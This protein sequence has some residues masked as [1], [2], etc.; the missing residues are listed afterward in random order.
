MK[1]IFILITIL[2]TQL[3][4]INPCFAI[5]I[6]LQT[7]MD[8]TYIGASTQ[9]QI[10]N[11]RTNKL[12]YTMA[13]MKG[14]EFRAYKNGMA[15]KVQDK[16]FN[17]DS[18]YVVIKP[19]DGGFISVKN[20]WYRGFF[21]IYNKNGMLTVINNVNIEDYIRG[22]VPSEMP[23]SWNYEAHKAQ[24]IASRSY[25]L[26]NL[27][28]RASSGYDLKDT[29]E[30]QAYG[31]ASAES[32]RT[33]KAVNE[34]SGIVLIYDLKIIPAYYSASAGG[35]TTTS[36][37]VWTKNLPYLQSVPSF[38]DNVKKNGHGVGMSQHG[39][40]NLAKSGYNAYQILQYF[41]K[42]VKF[43]RINKDFYK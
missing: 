17:L 12:L 1:K 25:A 11:G 29:P 24:A 38:D 14:Y 37:D 13:G 2:F 7:S 5:K 3:L 18:D 28:K 15:I 33:N 43:A 41:Y 23:S 4:F 19:C 31:G 27:G 40:N 32:S 39:A 16:Y 36:G 42:G 21:I 22:V 8:R 35:Q 9:A 10:I 34:T 26:A 30:D 6:G 20:K